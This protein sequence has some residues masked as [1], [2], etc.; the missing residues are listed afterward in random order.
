[1]TA[2]YSSNVFLLSGFTQAAALA[3]SL[4]FGALNWLFA[5]PAV[6]TVSPLFFFFHFVISMSVECRR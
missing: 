3:S 4:G 6:F 5:L 2:Y 1:M